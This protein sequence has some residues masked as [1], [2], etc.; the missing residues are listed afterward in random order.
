[1]TLRMQAGLIQDE[2]GV[3]RFVDQLEAASRI[4]EQIEK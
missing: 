3:T 1:M 2:H 4:V